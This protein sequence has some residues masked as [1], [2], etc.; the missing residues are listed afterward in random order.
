MSFILSLIL[1]FMPG[2][3]LAIGPGRQGFDGDG[4]ADISD[5]R[6]RRQYDISIPEKPWQPVPKTGPGIAGN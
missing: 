5:T 6:R 4:A 3:P 1:P 2:Q